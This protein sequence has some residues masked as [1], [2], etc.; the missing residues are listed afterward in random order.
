MV[1]A[2][3]VAATATAAAAAGAAAAE[4]ATVPLEFD[5]VT[6][7]HVADVNAAAWS[8]PVDVFPGTPRQP[9]LVTAAEE[10]RVMLWGA[11]D[12][13]LLAGTSSRYHC[14]LDPACHP[15]RF[16]RSSVDELSTSYLAAYD[17]IS[18]V[19]VPLTTPGGVHRRH[20]WHGWRRRSRRR[21]SPRRGLQPQRPPPRARLAQRGAPGLRSPAGCH[22]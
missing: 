3:A 7:G 11:L 4:V 13:R 6:N 19:I 5:E 20:R 16:R 17:V 10:R 15:S 2:A 1:A 8:P 18:I 14:L 9:L 12:Q 21:R 22:R